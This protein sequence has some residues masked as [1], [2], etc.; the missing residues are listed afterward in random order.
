MAHLS[1]GSN[2]DLFNLLLIGCCFIGKW[3]PFKELLHV[4]SLAVIERQPSAYYDLDAQLTKNKPNLISLLQH[5][6]SYL[7]VA[8]RALYPLI[9]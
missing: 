5:A 6:V 2:I 1:G 9:L 7:L 3:T 8:F 4:V